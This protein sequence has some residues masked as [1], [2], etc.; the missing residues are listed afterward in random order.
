VASNLTGVVD[1]LAAY[2]FGTVLSCLLGLKPASD[3]LPVFRWL[4]TADKS[5][6]TASPVMHIIVSH[7]LCIVLCIVYVVNESQR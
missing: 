2:L 5:C 3:C 1:V 4:N 6:Y 7:V